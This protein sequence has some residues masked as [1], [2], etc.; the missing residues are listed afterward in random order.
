MFRVSIAKIDMKRSYVHSDLLTDR[1]F[2]SL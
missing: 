2:T 1:F